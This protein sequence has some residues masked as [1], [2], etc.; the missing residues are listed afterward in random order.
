[1]IL[2]GDCRLKVGVSPHL[3]EEESII[4]YF[5]ARAQ[6]NDI[7]TTTLRQFH[8]VLL[9][10]VAIHELYFEHLYYRSLCIIR[11]LNLGVTLMNL[12][13]VFILYIG[14]C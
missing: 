7:H 5:L 1:M 8:H 14:L 9:S 6:G 11:H 2:L 12:K 3:F 4:R 10:C 13:L